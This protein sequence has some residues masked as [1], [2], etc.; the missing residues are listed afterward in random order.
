M[1]NALDVPFS[2]QILVFSKTSFQASRISPRTPRAIYHNDEV[3]V[4]WVKGGDVVEFAVADA[5]LGV[6]FYTMDQERV[7]RPTID[8]RG[9]ECLQC[10]DSGATLGVPGFVVRSVVPDR[11]G[12]PLFPG[13]AYLTDHRSPMKERWGGWY[14][15]G[16]H[17]D[18]RH[19]GN[20][21][22]EKGESSDQLDTEK[23]ANLTDLRRHFDNGA[24]LEPTSDL[25]A[26]MT[27]EHQTRM[28]NLI[29]RLNYEFRLERDTN[30]AVEELVKYMLF[31]DE[32]L[33][34]APVKGASNFAADFA[35]SAR[36]DRKGRSLRDLD[37]T[38]RL[39]KY[40][41][42]YLIY[43][44]LF[45]GLPASAKEQVYRRLWDV[46]NASDNNAAGHR[47][48]LEILIDTKP[49]LPTYWKL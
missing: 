39:L 29:S 4:G 3:T 43:S 17:G 19:M 27:I 49:G 28:T 25:V 15:T 34:D 42:S 8:R 45:D 38:R 24:Y 16:T 18:T 1:L 20:S 47:A 48:V 7:S 31:A 44:E 22:V 30:P 35:R 23:Y 32:A 21:F 36:R 13:I 37:L 5:R 46:L 9:N 10:H 33:L 41:C 12:M 2:S 11:S 40:P 14:V 26:L 6:V